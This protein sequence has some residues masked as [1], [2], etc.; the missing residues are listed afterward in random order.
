MTKTLQRNVTVGST[1]YGPSYPQ[2][3]PSGVEL[4]D[5]AYEAD[6]P[7]SGSGD[8]RFRADDFASEVGDGDV[9]NLRQRAEAAEAERQAADVASRDVVF[10]TTPAEGGDP[11]PSRR[12]TAA[13]SAAQG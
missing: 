3:D 11:T 13:K 5:W 12:R 4:P 7:E 9:P 8:L 1:T 10:G 2:N 6:P